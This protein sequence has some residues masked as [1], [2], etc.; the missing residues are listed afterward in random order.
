[1]C[2]RKENMLPVIL[3]AGLSRRLGGT[4]KALYE[5][6]GATLLYRAAR[7]LAYS[8][9]HRVA[10]VTGHGHELIERYCAQTRLPVAIELLHNDRYASLNNFYTVAVAC[11]EL[12]GPLLL[13]NTDVVTMPDAIRAA[14][15]G[16][17]SGAVVV[18]GSR[19]D[20]EAMG[21][22]VVEGRA[23]S[24]G[25]HLGAEESAGEFVGISVL[26]SEPAKD[27]FLEE[28]ERAVVA[29]ETDLYYEDIYARIAQRIRFVPMSI[30]TSDWAEIDNVDDLARAS[31][32]ARRQDTF[33]GSPA[34]SVGEVTAVAG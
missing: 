3:A 23:V 31:D 16:A 33:F 14:V 13:M 17:G 29:G 10:V 4:P 25:K 5:V 21:V 24:F 34:C 6:E 8:G 18:D 15:G 9:F 19:V 26:A 30:R 12:H 2:G 22:A 27:A 28:A 20:A 11:R 32:V 7:V 1:M